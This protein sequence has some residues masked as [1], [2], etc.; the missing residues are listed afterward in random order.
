M[1]TKE[2]WKKILTREE[3]DVCILKG[4][5]A[6]FTGK[7]NENKRDGIYK[8]KCCDTPLFTSKTK[9]DSGSGWPSFYKSIN[10]DAIE[11]KEDK[12]HSMVRVEVLCN[13]CSSHL[14]HIFDDGPYPTF[15]RYCI[16]SISLKFE[17]EF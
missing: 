5:E 7:Y 9:Y 15:K 4:T 16:N 1:K 17:E 6:P 3:F 12:T 11:Y 14:G 8:C 10:E 13:R 2:E